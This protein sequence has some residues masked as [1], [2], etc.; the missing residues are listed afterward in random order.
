MY[1]IDQETIRF[2]SGKKHRFPVAVAEV[3]DFEESIVVR[4]VEIQGMA[5]PNVMGLDYQ[6]N[7][8]WKMPAP[9][10]FVLQ[11]PYI[12]LFRKDSYVEVLNWDG[13]IVTL[14]PKRGAIVSEDFYSGGSGGYGHRTASVRR[15][16]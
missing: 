14:H 6:G 1:E 10:T 15:W 2:S 12:S 8:L 3:L 13:H 7:L 4:L 11:N 5:A 16:I 9:R